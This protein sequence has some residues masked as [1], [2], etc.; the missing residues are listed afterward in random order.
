MGHVQYR[1]FESKYSLHSDGII[2]RLQEMAKQMEADL[3][4]WRTDVEIL[5]SKYYHMNYF[6]TRQLS[7]ICQELS[8]LHTVTHRSVKP[9][10][11]NLMQ[12]VCP[13]LDTDRLA[14]AAVMVAEERERVKKSAFFGIGT[15]DN[16]LSP[17]E[18]D[19]AEE[20]P[21]KVSKDD[22]ASL[23]RMSTQKALKT[24]EL[25][26]TQQELF[27][28][29]RALD[30]SEELI[31]IALAEK[32]CSFEDLED[33]C[34]TYSTVDFEPGSESATAAVMVAEER[35]RVKKSVSFGIG[36]SYNSL[37]P[38]EF[39]GDEETPDKISKDDVASLQRMYTQKALKI[40]EL[41]ETQQEMFQELRALDYSEELILLALTEKGCS[42]DDL[43]DFCLT[44]NAID[45]EPGSKSASAVKP[46]VIVEEAQPAEMPLN[47]NHSQVRAMI[48]A[49]FDLELAIEAAEVCSCNSEQMLDYCLE[50]EY[51]S[52]SE[53][54]KQ[55]SQ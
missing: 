34:L 54:R 21:N 3:D 51:S 36:T 27:E 28:E 8:T 40:D 47:E 43:E 42:F 48:E 12:S 38:E 5:R 6:T 13:T 16:S 33:Y 14:T 41:N 20:T 29:L 26:E 50:K 11:I 2:N 55:D 46:E 32:G 22:V 37:S 9:W 53:E 7:L 49:G 44:Y 52:A 4:E 17:D 23:Q 18:F 39:N 24:D 31:L 45:F 25:N 30:Y 10:F 15:S 19:G 35:E 1:Q